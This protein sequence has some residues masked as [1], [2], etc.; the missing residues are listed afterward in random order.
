MSTFFFQMSLSRTLYRPDSSKFS[1]MYL[2]NILGEISKGEPGAPGP[3]GPMGIRGDEGE[4]GERGHPGLQGQKGE[5]VRVLLVFVFPR[6]SCPRQFDDQE[7]YFFHR[8]MRDPQDQ[9]VR[10]E[11]PGHLDV[12][13]FLVFP[14]RW[15]DPVKREKKVSI[16][17]L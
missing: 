13:E 12:T 1:P 3:M 6:I 5:Q 9:T 8:V 2:P 10:E 4:K 14:A 11:S 15:V 7:V 16:S 17:D